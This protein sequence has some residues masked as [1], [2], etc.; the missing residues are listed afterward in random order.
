MERPQVKV[1]PAG[2]TAPAKA[3]TPTAGS[4]NGGQQA[5]KPHVS[6]LRGVSRKHAASVTKRK[7][8][9]SGTG[10]A[11]QAAERMPPPA[12]RFDKRRKTSYGTW[13]RLPEAP[14]KAT[15]RQSGSR[16]LCSMGLFQSL[17]G[18]QCRHTQ[19]S[20]DGKHR[21]R[22]NEGPECFAGRAAALEAAAGQ[23]AAGAVQL[24]KP[25]ASISTMHQSSCFRASSH[26]LFARV[27]SSSRI[28]HQQHLEQ[29][30]SLAN[31]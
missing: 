23:R 28:N 6:A 21:S 11:A 7:R 12:P 18:N 3:V 20:C 4:G 17:S 29:R 10:E 22:H 19:R 13:L 26:D 14:T 16:Q 1:E 31:F 30:H 27:M 2:E 9:V 8:A 15:M 24:S 5:A 25:D